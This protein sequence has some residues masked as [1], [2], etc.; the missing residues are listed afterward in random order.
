MLAIALFDINAPPTCIATVPARR[1][2]PPLK[3]ADHR[4]HTPGR[5]WCRPHLCQKT[6]PL[7]FRSAIRSFQRGRVQCRASA[8]LNAHSSHRARSALWIARARSAL[9][10]PSMHR[11]ARQHPFCTQRQQRRR[12]ALESVEP[13]TSRRAL[14]PHHA[15]RQEKPRRAASASQSARAACGRVSH[16]R[17]RMM[18]RAGCDQDA[19]ACTSGG[20]IQPTL[21]SLRR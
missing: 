12:A 11:V 19:R 3:A 17:M 4:E 15:A 7:F 18:R 5:Q 9:C 13:A 1:D 10:S 21:P 20:S 2:T 6:L 16:G 14:A 8:G